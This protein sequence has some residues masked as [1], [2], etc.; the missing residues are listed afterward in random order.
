MWTTVTLE[1][2]GDLVSFMIFQRRIIFVISNITRQV[3][4]AVEINKA[5][6]MVFDQALVKK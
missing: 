2:S 5:E 4:F 1:Y 6:S 3:Q